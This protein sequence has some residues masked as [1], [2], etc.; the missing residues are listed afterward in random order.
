MNFFRRSQPGSAEWFESAGD[1]S[2]LVS[3]TRPVGEHVF[4][5]RAGGYGLMFSLPGVDTECVSDDAV[6]AM[7]SGLQT[8]QRLVPDDFITYQ[9][10]R[11]KRR[12]F[13]PK[14]KYTNSANS[15]IAETEQACEAHLAKVGF[16]SVELFL[17]VYATPPVGSRAPVARAQ[18][19]GELLMR[20][21]QVAE[22]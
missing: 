2:E 21:E 22:S 1:P 10:A 18:S 9:I 8:A 16:R 19:T 6:T 12:G 15:I 13:L 7:S 3:I 5:V 4:G 17:T 14:L 11:V 20:L